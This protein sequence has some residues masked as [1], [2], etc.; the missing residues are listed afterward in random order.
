M[1][2]RAV[3]SLI[4]VL[5]ALP[6][7]EAR[8]FGYQ[9][10]RV[11]GHVADAYLTPEARAAVRELLPWGGL[12]DH[13]NWADAIRDDN[14]ATAPWHYVNVAPEAEHYDAARD[15]PPAG[16]VV[17][18]IDEFRAALRDP[19]ASRQQRKDAL[20]WILH[21]VGDLHQPLHC[22]REVDRG[23]NS[24]RVRFNGRDTNLHAVWDTDLVEAQNLKDRDYAQLLIAEITPEQVEAWQQGTTADWTDESWQL[25]STAA[26]VDVDGEPLEDGA[27][28]GRRYAVERTAVLDRQLA[29]AGVRLAGV[30]NAAFKKGE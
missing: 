19:A 24:I 28:L 1:H 5:I 18:K 17:A 30:L 16:C 9:G 21:L 23:G 15:C 11:V 3:A 26:Y 14:P 6:G 20:R 12:A 10:H 25:A 7:P 22:A 8:A 4:A 2:H 29:K 27:K 13:S